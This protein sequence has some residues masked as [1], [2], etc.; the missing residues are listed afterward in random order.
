MDANKEEEEIRGLKKLARHAR[1][2]RLRQ[3]Y[4]AVRLILEG[5]SRSDVAGILG[6]TYQTVRNYT[7]TYNKLGIDGFRINKPSGRIKKLMGEQE[8]Q[9]YDCI[10]TR[11][12][13]DVGFAPF[14]NWTAP[15][16]CQWVQ[17][18]FGVTFSERG[19]RNVFDRIGLSYTRPTYTLKK[20]DLKK[21]EAFK[22][23]FETLKKTDFRG[24]R[25]PIL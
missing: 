7:I 11:L 10:A 3:R 5:R 8:R 4:D 1:D 19:M 18:E 20:A 15:L 22:E 13:K 12:P 2:S 17:K 14:V 21:Q 25:L 9:L 23:E 24:D 6:I 16:A